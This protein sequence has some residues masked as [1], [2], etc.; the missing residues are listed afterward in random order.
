MRILLSAFSC[1]PGGG[2]EPGVGWNWLLQ[3][4]RRHEV[5]LLTSDE[6]QAKIEPALPPNVHATF[7]PSFRTWDRLQKMI[8]PGLDWVYYYWWQWKAYRI[9][10]RLFREVRFDLAHHTTFCSWRVPSFLCLLPIPMIWGPVG[11]GGTAPRSLWGE[12]GRKGRFFEVFRL[13]CQQISRFDPLVRLTMKRAAV[14]F[15]GNNETGAL[16]PAVHRAKMR[17]MCCAGMLATDQEAAEMPQPPPEGFVVLSAGLLEPRKAFTLALRAFA[18]FARA[19]PDA[20]LVFT[21]RGPE[22]ERLEALATRLGIAERVRF[23]GGLP[24]RAQVLGWME[25]AD[26]F[27]FPSLRETSPMVLAE[28]MLAR[29]PIICLDYGGASEMVGD[30]C[31]LK[32][33]VGDPEQVV[34]SLAAALEKLAGDP[35]LGQAMGKAGRLRVLDQLDWDRRGEQMMRVYQETAE[36]AG[37]VNSGI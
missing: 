37:K 1:C 4:S 15:V 10:K 3:A 30:E 29:T 31:G 36:H 18:C 34:A 25:A 7:I 23:L 16:V 19:R 33:P 11:G 28:A 13:L 32:V 21:N 9:A 6:Y 17:V 27:L 14:I 8:V 2:S 26:V 5:W 35:S 12:L 22:R 20:L 24:R